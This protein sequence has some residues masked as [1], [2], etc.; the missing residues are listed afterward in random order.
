MG[1]A[2][3]ARLPRLHVSGGYYHV[4][5][6]GNHREELFAEPF[7]R[8]MLNDILGEVLERFGSRAHAFCWMTN[9]LH[10]LVQIADQPLGK[11]MQRIAM[12]Y[13]RYRHRRLKT[14]GHLFERRYRAKLVE[15]DAYVFA[16]LRYIHLNP[17]NAGMVTHPADYPWSSHRAYLGGESFPWLRIDTGLGLFGSTVTE[18]RQAYARWMAQPS[19][20]SEDRLW[21]D[22]HP[23]DARILGG[24]KFLA[25]LPPPMVMPRS[26]KTLEQLVQ[27]ICAVHAVDPQVIRSSARHRR[28]TAVRVAIARQAIGDRIASMPEVAR[29]LGRNSSSLSELL[30][31]HP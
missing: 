1:L 29:F 11:L 22:T 31:R 16:L 25:S 17:V 8:L 24:D 23:D 5:L 7:D 14:T 18:A 20:A 27:E 21:D 6:R 3:M 28:L 30:T 13:S 2:G 10:L 19:Y 26:R 4:M 12:R 9:H 15:M